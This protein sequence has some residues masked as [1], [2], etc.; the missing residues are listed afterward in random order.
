MA[1]AEIFETIAGP[2]APVEFQA[3][4]GSSAGAPGS[5]IKITSTPA[6][7]DADPTKNPLAIGFDFHFGMKARGMGTTGFSRMYTSFT[8]TADRRGVYSGSQLP[9]Q[10]NN[11][12]EFTY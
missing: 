8:S 2:D 6:P 11:L 4:D 7:W 10:N 12:Q 3:Y 5:P 9:E 1:L